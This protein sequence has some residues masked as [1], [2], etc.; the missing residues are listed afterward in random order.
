MWRPIRNLNT[1][2]LKTYKTEELETAHKALSKKELRN[3]QKQAKELEQREKTAAKHGFKLVPLSASE[4]EEAGG[5]T[6]NSLHDVIYSG[7][8]LNE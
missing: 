5:K 3:R 2:D 4:P 8:R 6:S 7:L 1:D